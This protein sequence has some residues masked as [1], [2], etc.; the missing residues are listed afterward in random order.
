MRN[1]WFVPGTG[2]LERNTGLGLDLRAS[3]GGGVGRYLLQTNRSLLGAAGGLVVNRE[4]PV[5]GDSTTNLEALVAAT[6]EFFT[7]DTP[8][9]NIDM[10]F[11]LYPSLNVS[12]RYGTDF[13]LNIGW[14]C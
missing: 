14:T 3:A 5:D 10:T 1:C 8:K 11:A 13:S 7:Y 6:Y 4:N 9:T 2:K 12:G